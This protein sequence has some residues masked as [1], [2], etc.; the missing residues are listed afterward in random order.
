[1]FTSK[2]LLIVGAGGGYDVFGGL[3][4]EHMADHVVY[5][6]MGSVKGIT[7]RKSEEQDSP[8]YALPRTVYTLGREGCN[9]VKHGLEEI[10]KIHNIDTILAVDG[11]IDSIMRGDEAQAGT[12]LEDF[13]TLGAIN[14]IQNVNKLLVCIGFGTEIE[15]G[16]NHDLALENMSEIAKNGGFLG[17]YAIVPN[18]TGYAEYKSILLKTWETKRVSHI[19]GRI[20]PAIEGEIESPYKIDANLVAKSFESTKPLS[21]LSTIAWWFDLDTVVSL[22]PVMK[23]LVNSNTFTDAF[24]FLRAYT[25]QAKLRP[26]Y[27]QKI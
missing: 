6:T 23:I 7:V 14:Q 21:L 13:I 15:E 5:A 26:I 22:K 3:L 25:Q 8:E 4:F 9:S 10:I 19:H 16:L 1:M 27:G 12:I 20:I 2:N 18:S 17:A 11:G 24:S